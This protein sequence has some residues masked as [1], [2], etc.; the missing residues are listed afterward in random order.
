MSRVNGET[1]SYNLSSKCQQ[2]APRVL[3][4]ILKPIYKH[5]FPSNK[6]PRETSVHILF[7]EKNTM[8][9]KCTILSGLWISYRV[10]RNA[11]WL[12]PL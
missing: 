12:G 9:L 3:P 1:S 11:V 7:R 2:N 8:K 10:F 4:Q 6:K 5:K